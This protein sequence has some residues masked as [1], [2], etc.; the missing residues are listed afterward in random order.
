M[1]CKI[2]NAD[3]NSLVTWLR[4][5]VELIH[6]ATPSQLYA[7]GS[8]SLAAPGSCVTSFSGSAG[9]Q[10]SA[11][12]SDSLRSWLQIRRRGGV[13]RQQRRQRDGR[14][15]RVRRAPAGRHCGVEPRCTGSISVAKWGQPA[16]RQPAARSAHGQAVQRR[17][18][19]LQLE[20]GQTLRPAAAPQCVPI[21]YAD[22]QALLCS[23]PSC[24][25]ACSDRR[26]CGIVNAHPSGPATVV[27]AAAA[28]GGKEAWQRARSASELLPSPNFY[29]HMPSRSD[30]DA[31][32][33][34][35]DS[36]M[37]LLPVANMQESGTGEIRVTSSRLCNSA[38]STFMRRS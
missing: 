11:V 18:H 19:Q 10:R 32:P 7:Q 36:V 29:V 28:A 34:D 25:L 33:A 5:V 15:A 12:G 20:R 16:A 14:H 38:Q 24:Q 27:S 31:A 22:E 35:G 9:G 37:V 3:I 2:C 8:A 30:P 21:R 4:Q 13:N 1:R 23:E 26:W 17:R 6:A